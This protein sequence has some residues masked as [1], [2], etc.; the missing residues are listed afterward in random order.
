[1][2]P[3]AKQPRL[4]VVDDKALEAQAI[5]LVKSALGDLVSPDP[6]NI[7]TFVDTIYKHLLPPKEREAISLMD[8][9]Y[10]DSVTHMLNVIR[11]RGPYEAPA[12]NVWKSFSPSLKNYWLDKAKAG[13]LTPEQFYEAS[14][15]F[16]TD[17]DEKTRILEAGHYP[18]SLL[19]LP[20]LLVQDIKAGLGTRAIQAKYEQESPIHALVMN[21]WIK[22]PEFWE[23]LA[24]RD[25]R[26]P[27]ERGMEKIKEL[28]TTRSKQNLGGEKNYEHLLS[29]YQKQ[30]PEVLSGLDDMLNKGVFSEATYIAF[31]SNGAAKMVT[32][33]VTLLSE[34]T[35]T[36]NTSALEGY[37]N[38][39]SIS[40]EHQT[41]GAWATI[42]VD[43]DEQRH[44]KFDV[45]A[46]AE[47]CKLTGIDVITFSMSYVD[48]D[49]SS[50]DPEEGANLIVSQWIPTI[51]QLLISARSPTEF[52]LVAD[53]THM[54]E[55]IA[56]PGETSVDLTHEGCEDSIVI[57]IETN[58]CPI[59][60]Y[61]F[62]KKKK[63]SEVTYPLPPP[64]KPSL[65]GKSKVEDEE[66]DEV[67]VA[68]FQYDGEIE[69]YYGETL[70]NLLSD[71][72]EPEASKDSDDEMDE[73]EDD[74]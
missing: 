16:V 12:E 15:D 72:P 62:N 74:M 1:M 39:S 25:I 7:V 14:L 66:D 29:L 44:W 18:S 60:G 51:V 36:M 54:T 38:M 6:K 59:M 2:E 55:D 48:A 34:A 71:L 10:S 73:D 65:G 28:L 49:N 13:Q 35:R 3:L 61:H 17:L 5:T 69:E 24:H 41:H 52:K 57:G 22:R 20:R 53:V 37:S 30:L 70:K 47:V 31:F 9:S 27:I 68:G 21:K 56:F 63:A 11:N 23:A 26:L 19:A 42:S 4:D 8:Y 64:P 32:S 43:D 45:M 50:S 33:A 40:F 46:P 67:D 58:F